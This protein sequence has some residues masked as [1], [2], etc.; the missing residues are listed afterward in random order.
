MYSVRFA[1][2]ALD[3]REGQIS[4]IEQ[5][6]V[7][8]RTLDLPSVHRQFEKTDL[9]SKYGEVTQMEECESTKLRVAGSSPALPAY[10]KY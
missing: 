7:V 5:S 4:Q 6:W 10:F 1:L 9:R 8:R 3:M 2:A